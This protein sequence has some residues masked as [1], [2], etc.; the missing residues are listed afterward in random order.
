[1]EWVGFRQVPVPAKRTPREGP[2]SYSW[3]HR[4]ALA[5]DAITS[6]S[7]APMKALL[8]A[9]I[10]LAALALLAAFA[11]AALKIVNPGYV[12]QGFTALAVLVLFSLG[13]ILA[14]IGMV[15]L[16]LGKVFLQTKN[17]PLYVI[18]REI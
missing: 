18:R 13:A 4:A 7:V 6:F 8:L 16:Y 5:F 3:L 9:G 14:A 11:L 10:G 15:G 17:R 1:M 12:L 2:P